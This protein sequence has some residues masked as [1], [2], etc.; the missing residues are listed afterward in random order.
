[1]TVEFLIKNYS[2]QKNLW[3]GNG[4]KLF[5]FE[6]I[7]ETALPL[8]NSQFGFRRKLRQ[9]FDFPACLMS[10]HSAKWLDTILCSCVVWTPVRTSL[11]SWNVAVL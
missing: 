9:E 5:G 11:F 2:V 7:T 10:L 1:M 3:S 8:N 6:L 4:L